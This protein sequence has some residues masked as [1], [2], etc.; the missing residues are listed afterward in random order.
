M[1]SFFRLVTGATFMRVTLAV[2]AVFGMYN[3]TGLHLGQL[4]K[5]PRFGLLDANTTWVVLIISLGWLIALV[6]V[7]RTS[8][9]ELGPFGRMAA[10]VAI[11]LVVAWLVFTNKLDYRSTAFAAWM[12]LLLQGMLFALFTFSLW[13]P[14]L[15]RHTSG[16]NTTAITGDDEHHHTAS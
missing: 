4:W 16:V 5:L 7:A 12:V 6:Y 14:Q 2:F 1:R 8:W 15:R 11:G 3:I 13:I 9:K 10:T